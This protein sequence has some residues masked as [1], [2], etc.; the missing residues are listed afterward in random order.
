MS[1]LDFAELMDSI[2]AEDILEYFGA[3]YK[4]TTGSHGHQLN[5][6]EC[7]FCGG[8]NWKVYVNEETGLG[9][10]FHGDCQVKFN[11]FKLARAFDRDN[12]GHHT[13]QL[14]QELAS[15]N[16]WRPR[17]KVIAKVAES[18]DGLPTNLVELAPD[19]A[20]SQYLINRGINMDTAQYFHLKYARQGSQ[21]QYKKPDGNLGYQ[22]YSNRIII[23]V[24]DLEGNLK[25]FQGRD[26]T[27]LSS[28]KYMFPP[29]VNASGSF[30]Y[31]G[32]NVVGKSHVIVC[33]G[34]FDVIAV[35]LAIDSSEFADVGVVGTFGMHLS[36]NGMNSQVGAFL[37]LKEQ[38]LKVVTFMWD[39]EYRAHN[40]AIKATRE[41]RSR[42]F[43][44]R[45]AMLPK[46]KDPNEVSA[47]VVRK[48][49]WEA[50]SINRINELIALL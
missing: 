47:E 40:A 19:A 23:P 8:G 36:S 12:S 37:R 3:R 44:V 2:S 26:V 41:L 20:S 21:W 43:T 6:R 39:G 18:V 5:V 14:L 30:L 45:I 48:C 50:D 25:T 29:G 1:E 42:G 9:N 28:K 4:R 38:G 15:I 46:D 35:H 22:D 34:V 13:V 32:H 33:E 31:N 49:F 17:E 11:K 7:P 24:Y 16:G 27:G 10:C